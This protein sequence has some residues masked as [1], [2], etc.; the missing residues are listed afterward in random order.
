MN[1]DDAVRRLGELGSEDDPIIYRGEETT[2][3]QLEDHLCWT[4]PAGEPRISF[5]GTLANGK[6]GL[7]RSSTLLQMIRDREEMFER[8]K[9]EKTTLTPK[10]EVEYI[11]SWFEYIGY[12]KPRSHRKIFTRKAEA[13]K[14]F[15]QKRRR[16]VSGVKMQ[17]VT[18]ELLDETA[19]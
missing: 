14:C 1:I 10:R 15:N 17:R 6:F 13:K 9:A 19:P 7:R 5:Y 3:R 12:D 8:E 11:V 18:T 4:T 16:F 2:P